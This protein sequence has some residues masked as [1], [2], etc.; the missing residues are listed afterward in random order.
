[1]RTV[2]FKIGFQCIKGCEWS[3][4]NYGYRK[5]SSNSKG[6]KVLFFHKADLQSIFSKLKKSQSTGVCF[7]GCLF[8]CFVLRLNPSSLH[9]KHF[10]V[11]V[12]HLR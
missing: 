9:F 2:T 4:K 5:L 8:V 10:E 7:F 1:M 6:L 3:F 12:S 11:L